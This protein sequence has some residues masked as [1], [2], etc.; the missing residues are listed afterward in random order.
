MPLRITL[1]TGLCVAIG[2]CGD[3]NTGSPVASPGSAPTVETKVLDAGAALV[4]GKQPL[5]SLNLYLDGFHF[6][7]GDMQAQMEAHHYCSVVNEEVSQ[8]L[9][10]DGN[11]RDA[12]LVGVEYI[13]SRR[14]FETLDAEERKLWHSHVYEVKSGQLIAPGVPQVAENELMEKLV[15]TYGKTWHTWHTD[16]AHGLPLGHPMLMMGFTADGQAAQELIAERD[17][18]FE[19][20]SQEKRAQ[21][22][23]IATPAIVAGAD[24]WTHGDVVQLALTPVMIPS[25][26]K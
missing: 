23:S 8:C 14:L 1:L 3:S 10:F 24:A 6:H 15:D 5:Q 20:S 17:R 2:G 18:R 22:T 19:V 16:R 7:N 25:Q 26:S 9:I 13:V 21:R 11:A 4:Q 12:K